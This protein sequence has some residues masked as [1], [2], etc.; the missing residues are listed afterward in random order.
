[1]QQTVPPGTSLSLPFPPPKGSERGGGASEPVHVRPR[2]DGHV[3]YRQAG[4]GTRLGTRQ[5]D[6][7]S[8]QEGQGKLPTSNMIP[9][10]PLIAI[11]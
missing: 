4:G 1:M 7:G 5:H 10:S 6:E 9:P 2:G 11:G 8:P 3:R